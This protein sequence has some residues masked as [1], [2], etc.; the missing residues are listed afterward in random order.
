MKPTKASKVYKHL[1]I[2]PELWRQAKEKAAKKNVLLSDLIATFIEQGL[3][4]HGTYKPK[5][6]FQQGKSRRSMIQ[7]RQKQVMN[8]R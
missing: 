4:Q 5:P 2:K 3:R 6:K 8:L 1:S 7:N